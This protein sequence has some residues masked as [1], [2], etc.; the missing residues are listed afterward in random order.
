MLVYE[1]SFIS[2][3]IVCPFRTDRFSEDESPFFFLFFQ[4]Y[5]FKYDGFFFQCET[6]WNKIQYI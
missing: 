3:F 2:L 1:I 6:T 4:L 5:A